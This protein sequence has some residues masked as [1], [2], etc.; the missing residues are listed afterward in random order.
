MLRIHEACQLW[1]SCFPF[2]WLQLFFQP[3][4]QAHQEV[5]CVR[6]C[7]LPPDSF[8]IS[9]MSPPLQ[10]HSCH[11]GIWCKLSP[12]PSTWE[13]KAILQ[14]DWCGPV[15][16][17]CQLPATL[18]SFKWRHFECFPFQNALVYSLN[19]RHLRRPDVSAC[20]HTNVYLPNNLQNHRFPDYL[21]LT[22]SFFFF[23]KMLV[24]SDVPCKLYQ[25]NVVTLIEQWT[26]L[27]SLI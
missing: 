2:F 21:Q 7:M 13:L 10:T 3:A 18:A 20:S 1:L 17:A 24:L 9:A 11:R 23:F 27:I 12:R 15:T 22:Q 6:V 16:S 26:K 4:Q 25:Q 5:Q 14:I 8:I 19:G